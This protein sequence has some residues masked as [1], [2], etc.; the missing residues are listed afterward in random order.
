MYLID[1]NIFLE[2]LQG[3]SKADECINLI[4]SLVY[5]EIPVFISRFGLYTIEIIMVRNKKQ[6]SLVKF[7]E[8]L[9]SY[10]SIKIMSTDLNED[11]EILKTAEKQKLDFDDALHYYL[12]TIYNLR[13]ISYD[14]HFDKTP[15]KRLE[16]RDLK[17]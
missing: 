7:I 13:L 4:E 2:F 9:T 6:S 17:L 8:F 16:P 15:I 3:Q 10:N 1:T 11:K 5:K 12:C 14:K